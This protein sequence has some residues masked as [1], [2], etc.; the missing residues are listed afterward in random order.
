M[1]K[2][3]A[4]AVSAPFPAPASE[5]ESDH[6]SDYGFDPQ[7]LHFPSQPEAKRPWG[8]RQRH[9]QPAQ[10]KPLD[11]AR[12]KLQKPIAK[13]HHR[14]Q[15][16]QQR[17][18]WW[19]S[20]ASAALH[21]FRKRPSSTRPAAGAPPP[22]YGSPASPTVPMYLTDCDA[23][24]DDGG[25]ASACT[26]WAP[27]VRSGRLAAAELGAAAV[28]VPYVSLRSTSLGTGGAPVMPIYLV[29]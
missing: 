22:Q 14:Q 7:L 19:S 11:S 6:F 24:G 25:G 21:L 10:L 13:K 27:A 15:K 4:A 3:R 18:R 2:K 17:R 16:Q 12:F 5:P 20:A 1:G 29:T 9:Q 28:A 23:G 8:R 26:C